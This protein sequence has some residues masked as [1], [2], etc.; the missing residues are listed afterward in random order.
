MRLLVLAS[1]FAMALSA[2]SASSPDVGATRPFAEQVGTHADALT[3]GKDATLG[4]LRG[5][6]VAYYD[7]RNLVIRAGRGGYGARATFDVLVENASYEKNV[8]IVW[9]TN[10]WRDTD[11]CSLAFAETMVDGRER[12]SGTCEVAH[13]PVEEIE[14]AAF[15]TLGGTTYWDSRDGQNYVLAFDPLTGFPPSPA[16]GVVARG[17]I[18]PAP[19]ESDFPVFRGAARGYDFPGAKSA[20]IVFTIDGWQIT[21][22]LPATVEADG[23]FW[24]SQTLP[25]EAER[26]EYAVVYRVGDSE[27]WA[28]NGGANY[29]LAVPR[30]R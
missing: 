24:W 16:T 20:A 3:T 12:W 18:E 15:A 27:L 5:R 1:S 13:G 29:V 26:V 9:T 8:G 2:C 28:N 30:P 21:Q 4:F 10:H 19:T 25:R 22:V 6:P 11:T 17:A 23:H 14:L 7:Y